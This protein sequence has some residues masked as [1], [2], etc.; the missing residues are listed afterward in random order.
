VIDKTVELVRGRVVVSGNSGPRRI[1]QEVGQQRSGAD[2]VLHRQEMTVK[3]TGVIKGAVQVIHQA[4][5]H[6]AGAVCSGIGIGQDKLGRAGAE[7]EHSVQAGAC[8]ERFD[9]SG[10]QGFALGLENGAGSPPTGFAAAVTSKSA[11]HVSFDR[12]S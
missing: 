4:V 8:R 7:L 3:V 9:G 11:G 5:E 10:F 12:V 2:S 1:W 6:I